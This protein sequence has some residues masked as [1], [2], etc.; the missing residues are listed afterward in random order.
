MD[1]IPI[2]IPVASIWITERISAKAY[3]RIFRGESPNVPISHK[4]GSIFLAKLVLALRTGRCSEKSKVAHK[5]E[6]IERICKYFAEIND[7][8]IVCP[9]E[10]HMSEI[11]PEE[12]MG[13]AN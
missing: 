2:P 5:E 10:Y 8:P 9:R 7:L 11:D 12:D 6:W 13:L 3:K 1:Q 4:S